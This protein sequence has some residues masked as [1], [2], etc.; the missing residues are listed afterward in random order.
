MR[1]LK[2]ID[3]FAGCGG[4]TLGLHQAGHRLLFAVEKDP[5]AFQTFSANFL[6]EGAPY[7]TGE[8]W[9]SW[10]P[11][12]PLDIE[13]LLASSQT[14]GLLST[15]RGKVDVVVG[16][17]P[18]QG[19]SVGGLRDGADNR[20]QLPL[21][22]LDF[23]KLVRPRMLLMENVEGMT[24][25]FISKPSGHPSSFA[26]W[27]CSSLRRSGYAANFKVIDA[28]DYGVPQTRRRMFLFGILKSE[29]RP[30]CSADD[31]FS[32]LHEQREG[33]LKKKGLPVGRQVTAR[34][35]IEDLSG[36]KTVVC[37]DSPKFKAGTYQTATSPYAILMRNGL[38]NSTIP[39]S[40]R[41][42]D[43][44]EDTLRFYRLVHEK[45]MF[46]RL[47][48]SF[49][50]ACGTK[51]EK[52]VL[53]DP[54]VPCSTITTHPDEFIHFLSP[55]NISV[56]EMARIQS[57][58]D[59]FVFRGRYT[60]NGDRRRYDVARCSQVGNAVPPLLAEALGVAL[61][62]FATRSFLSKRPLQKSQAQ[63]NWLCAEKSAS[64]STAATRT[65]STRRRLRPRSCRFR[66]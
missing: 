65:S 46:G 53:L 34:E 7:P 13:Q 12:N 42:S 6:D 57:F 18:C 59:A 31:F 8:S 17:P 20:N 27:L 3:L 60:I 45:K 5:M 4:F 49:L 19:F 11:K 37:P 28:S 64:S 44:G 22:Y 52:K 24:R 50:R 55:R 61:S 16:G 26:E 39:D 2:T 48:K 10:V 40:H 41:F 14:R 66:P 51:K 21:R 62:E 29:L 54:D 1:A 32:I 25:K 63:F 56:R 15:L 47:P 43:H 23:V 38:P 9:P 33:L 58:P 36:D 30:A 35:A